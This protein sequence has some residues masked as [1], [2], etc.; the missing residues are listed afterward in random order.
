MMTDSPLK[1]SVVVATYCPGEGLDRLIASLDAQTL[2]SS[3]WEAIF[4]DDGSP[5]DTHDRLLSLAITR[6]NMRVE[7]I[8]NSGWPCRPRNIG[9]DLARGEYVLYMDHDDE[10]YPEAL[11]AG[12]DFAKAAG[13]DAL[14]GKEARTHLPSWGID[15]FRAD[16]PQVL[17]DASGFALSPTNPHKLYRRELL[18]EHG[19]RFREGGRVL[20]EDVF[21]NVLVAKH[22]QVIATMSSEPFYHWYQTK[23][24]GSTTFLR[25]TREWWYWF[26]QVL[27]TIATE[28][29][30][31]RLDAQRERLA[32][33][34]YRSRLIDAFN[35]RYAD[36]PPKDRKLIFESAQLLQE[37]YF[38]EESDAALNSSD[39]MRA[40]LLR[41]GYRHVLERLTSDDPGL[42]GSAAVR[43]LAWEDGALLVEVDGRWSDTDGRVHGLRAEGGRIVKLL[44]AQYDGLFDPELL[45]VTDEIRGASVELGVRSKRTRITWMVPTESE[46]RVEANGSGVGFGVH[47]RARIDPDTAAFGRPLERTTWELNAR[48]TLAGKANQPF[49]HGT[50]APAV[51]ITERGV[52]AAFAR[53]D[54]RVVID[55]D[56][57]ERKLTDLVRPGGRARIAG[58]T[59]AVPVTGLPTGHDAVIDTRVSIDEETASRRLLRAAGRQLD[60]LRRRRPRG[61]GWASVPA[62]IRIA[63]GSASLEFP[64]QWDGALRVRLGALVPGSAVVYAIAQDG[65][66]R[67]LGR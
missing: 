50:P 12:Y 6:E 1:V 31:P 59:V 56:Q 18:N 23:G 21:F 62:T 57:S 20:W 32:A 27:E 67:P 66:V 5:D 26:E 7:R 40:Q 61:G 46:C 8:E 4:V 19:I 36:R 49:A 25:S 28:L 33:H 37:T 24:S 42:L 64:A 11:R 65:E 43:G 3:E 30:E 29:A 14:N 55:F 48:M 60:R 10:I 34:Q 53:P 9:T 35:N 17:D 39:R 47:G 51:E 38:P 16:A 2:P 58:G 52:S 44:P 45:D 41:R 63:S 54:G 13:A 22:A 15:E